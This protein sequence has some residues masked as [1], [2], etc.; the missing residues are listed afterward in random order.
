M[1][2]P[3]NPALIGAFVLGAIALLVVAVLLFGGTELFA[4]KVLLVS[5]FPDSVKGLREGANVLLRGVRVGYV[6]TITLDGRINDE[7]GTLD[8]L[9]EVIMEVRPE[10]FA[11]FQQAGRS[12][13]ITMTRLPA[14]TEH[15]VDAGFRAQLG[16]DSFVTG[17][18]LVELD[19]KPGTEAIFRGKSPP[20]PEVP[21]LPTGVQQAFERLQELI[22]RL[23]T[24][25]DTAQ[26][27]GD[28]QGIASGL[29]E[30]ANSQDLRDGF[31]GF[32]QL[33]GTDVPELVRALEQSAADLR[34]LLADTRSLVA[35]IDG[36]V[37]PVAAELVPAIRRLND[38]LAAGEQ[39]LAAAAAQ[40]RSDS[41]I[42][43][44]MNATLQELQGAA[45]SLR[46]LLDYVDRHPEALL[47]GKRGS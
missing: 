24:E 23:S 36:Q 41:E 39:A 5:Y 43:V 37:E 21:T 35:H 15:F 47:R 28:V 11:L 26:L 4:R 2:K 33:A 38:T 17:Q 18:F 1:S 25:L 40:I 27:L 12:Q 45:R 30:L 31:A 3:T 9:V 6:K 14:E 19:F 42:A 44:E 29:N 20:Y 8:A 10:T 13:E 34:G 7:R 16:I 22:G 32:N 46:I